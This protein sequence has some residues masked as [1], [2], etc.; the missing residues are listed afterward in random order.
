MKRIIIA[1]AA[2]AL[3]LTGACSKYQTVKG[4][5]MQTKIYTLDNGL[6]VYMT[7]NHDE[8]RIQTYIAVR[9]GGKNDPAD[10][11][12]LAHYL[13]HMM[14]K[15]SEAFGTTDY[16]AEQPML[17]AIDS[18]FEVYR[19][20]TD[21]D[22]RLAIYH[23]ID[24]ISFE[25]S[26]LA[27]PNEYDKMMSIIGSEGSNAYTSNDVTC[28]IENIPS[29]Q[30]DNWARIQA[31]RFINC[32]FRGFHT[33]LEAVYEE[34]NMGLVRDSEK[35]IDA[36]DS[37]LFA[38]HPYGTQTVIGTQEH[39]KNPSLKAIRYQKDTYYVPNNTAICLSG[40]FDPDEMVKTIEKYFGA[41]QP[42]PSLPVFTY[43][44]E[45]PITTQKI[46]EVVG[47]DAEFVFVGWRT[48]GEKD[49]R[50]EVG[51]IATSILYNGMAGLMDINVNNAQKALF[52]GAFVYDRTDYDILLTQ[53][54]AKA[55]QSLEEVKDL[56]LGEVAKLREGDFDDELVTATINNIKLQEMRSLESNA[57]RA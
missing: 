19:T 5:P 54:Q 11:T 29:N 35:A 52:A 23:V 28:Y 55:G 37:M 9:S 16:A 3:F 20:K 50:S 15:G 2:A 39:L 53:G 38:R 43:E 36:L 41:W 13:E 27:I 56:I 30:V 42:N 14:F 21:N 17:A 7:V 24:S 8:P 46:K 51:S 25:A 1:A 26:R 57:D 32:V 33:E 12:G 40:D 34:K 22:E 6:K 48:P 49:T 10:N 45:E 4:D 31:D 44:E 18:L 47:N